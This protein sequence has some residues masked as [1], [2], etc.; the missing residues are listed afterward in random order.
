MDNWS[1]VKWHCQNYSIVTVVKLLNA[2][3]HQPPPGKVAG[4]GRRR[5][6]THKALSIDCDNGCHSTDAIEGE[7]FLRLGWIMLVLDTISENFN[8]ESQRAHLDDN[9]SRANCIPLGFFSR[10]AEAPFTF[11]G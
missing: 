6:Q 9:F 10:E 1:Q 2:L 7:V 11:K 5:P 4:S 3:C 8:P